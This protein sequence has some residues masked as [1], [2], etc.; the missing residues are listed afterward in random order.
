MIEL[1]R[2]TSEVLLLAKT[3]RSTSQEMINPLN[4]FP[5]RFCRT[6][7]NMRLPSN[8]PF[9]AALAAPSTSRIL[10]FTLPITRRASTSPPP[11][12]ISPRLTTLPNKLR[13]VTEGAPTYVHSLGVFI[14]GG[15]RFESER[16]SGVTHLLDKM[17]FKVR[18]A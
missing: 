6:F 5:S 10:P 14:D 7:R 4:S 11:S 2:K 9:K 3:Q 13:V 18:S 17:A 8:S 12:S 1:L 16:T 15:T